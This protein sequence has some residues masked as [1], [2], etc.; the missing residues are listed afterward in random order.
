MF[1]NLRTRLL[2]S[3]A[4]VVFLC[5]FLAGS[6]FVVLLS[7]YQ[8][9]LRL[10]Q[11][12]DLAVPV[13][14]QVRLLELA[15]APPTQIAQ[16][17][18]EQASET[19]VRMLLLDRDGRVLTDTANVLVG[20]VLPVPRAAMQQSRPGAR[21]GLLAARDQGHLVMISFLPRDRPL[22]LARSI[23]RP[24]AEVTRASEAMAH[25]K[26]EQSI[27][28]RGGDELGRL[29]RAFNAMARQVSASD[30]AMRD[31]LANV[32]HDLRTPLTAIQGF[33]QAMT[34]GTLRETQEFSAAGRII[35]EESA[36]MQRLVE[37]I[38]YLSKLEAGQ[39][40]L[41]RQPV[42]VAELFARLERR[43]HLLAEQRQVRL[44]AE[45]AAQANVDADLTRLEQMLSNL[46][47][48]ALEHTPSGGA[49]S[50]R[51]SPAQLDGRPA[52]RLEVHNSGSYLPAEEAERV[53]ERFYQSDRARRKSGHGLGLAIVRELAQA[54]GGTVVVSSDPTAGTTFAVTLAARPAP[55]SPAAAGRGGAL[56]A[57]H[58]PSGSGAAKGGL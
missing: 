4:F 13:S 39:V 26:Y 27:P 21:W 3:Y 30:R 20:E 2:V 37:D 9:Q 25:G 34:D 50:F 11:L 18:R 53:F 42:D 57:R 10:N 12:A 46:L 15:G 48:N 35:H 31:F 54:H 44:V 7:D 14:I 41:E 33:S 40:R 36:R 58:A 1:L 28:V 29:A 19:G 38:L 22:L 47:D 52:W 16:T 5:L 17:L 51:A 8:R 49:V 43:Y 24:V 6:A 55:S 56:A 23:A 32:S 45:G